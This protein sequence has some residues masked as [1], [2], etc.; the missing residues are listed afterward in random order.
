MQR[1]DHTPIWEQQFEQLVRQQLPEKLDCD[2]EIVVS[3]YTRRNNDARRISEQI[4]KI[5]ETY[6]TDGR[7]RSWS[8]R[9]RPAA[10][11]F[12]VNSIFH[13]YPMR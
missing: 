7:V 1:E 11:F 9:Q 6:V 13:I 5:V 12:T 2:V 4:I 3:S 10:S 8:V